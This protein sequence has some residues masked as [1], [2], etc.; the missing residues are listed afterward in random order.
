MSGPGVNCWPFGNTYSQPTD[1][2]DVSQGVGVFGSSGKRRADLFGPRRCLVMGF[3]RIPLSTGSIKKKHV[4][5]DPI[6]SL[7]QLVKS[8]F[9]CLIN[10]LVSALCSGGIK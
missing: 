3:A 6:S 1:D 9:H 8:F 2:A 7:L 10:G 4:S 5:I